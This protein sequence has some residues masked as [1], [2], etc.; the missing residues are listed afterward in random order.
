MFDFFTKIPVKQQKISESDP[1]MICQKKDP[2]KIGF[3]P[4]PP[5]IGFS[6]DPVLIRA[7]LWQR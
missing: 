5:E 2:P 6:P 4:D 3:S 1:L 7:H